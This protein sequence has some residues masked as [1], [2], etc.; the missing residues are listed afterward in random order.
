MLKVIFLLLPLFLAISSTL[1]CQD[2]SSLLAKCR[3]L[4][5][6]DLIQDDIGCGLEEHCCWF[7]NTCFLNPDAPIAP[8]S[9]IN[10]ENLGRRF[11]K[12]LQ[13][14]SAVEERLFPFGGD[15]GTISTT[16]I[17]SIVPLHLTPP[18]DGAIPG[19]ENCQSFPHNCQIVYTSLTDM[20]LSIRIPYCQRLP[21]SRGN[22]NLDSNAEQCLA[23]PGCVYDFE[24]ARYRSTLNQAV[25]PNV[26]VCHLVVRSKTFQTKAS[27]FVQRGG[28]W[29]PL[30]TK[31]L[32]DEH[33]N[34]ILG[35]SAGC[36]MIRM[37]E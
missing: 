2:T 10:T 37:L 24:L 35:N 20:L 34:D 28:T 30:L 12:S 25:L 36:K 9:E 6:G 29:N 19:L 7:N 13:T 33:R 22:P 14:N 15:L 11:F 18:A 16:G 27:E 5:T 8:T 1:S 21:C 3:T 17:Q 26:P 32:I 23:S 4:K 31:C